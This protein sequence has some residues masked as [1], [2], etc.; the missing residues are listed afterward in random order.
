MMSRRRRFEGPDIAQFL[1]CIFISETGRSSNFG[2]PAK[3][4][5]DQD[6]KIVVEIPGSLDRLPILPQR[7][8]EPHCFLPFHDHKLSASRQQNGDSSKLW[9]DQ[10]SPNTSMKNE[11]DNR[12]DLKSHRSLSH[13]YGPKRNGKRTLRY[14]PYERHGRYAD[15]IPMNFDSTPAHITSSFHHHN[16]PLL[17]DESSTPEL[18]QSRWQPLPRRRNFSHQPL[19]DN[20]K[21]INESRGCMKSRATPLAQSVRS[22]QVIKSKE[23]YYYPLEDGEAR[24]IA[25]SATSLP[26]QS[27]VIDSGK[28]FK[29]FPCKICLKVFD[30]RYGLKRH[31]RSHTGERPYKCEWCGKA[32]RQGVHLKGHI[33]ARHKSLIKGMGD[34]DLQ[35]MI[36]PNKSQMQE[37]MISQ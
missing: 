35:A 11:N 25:G 23:G 33:L 12:I 28:I 6:G 30:S 26:L 15:N 16:V 4:Y 8:D 13:S 20:M 31:M 32:F 3:V 27:S 21:E 19:L 14:R 9:K 5:R 18:E 2:V 10:N 7:G 24:R 29:A 36:K 17:P 37:G 1:S 22:A 34:A